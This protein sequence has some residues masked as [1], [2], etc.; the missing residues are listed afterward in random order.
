MPRLT[1]EFCGEFV[2]RGSA[3]GNE[4]YEQK[5]SGGRVER[6]WHSRCVPNYAQPDS[7]FNAAVQ[8]AKQAIEDARR[9]GQDEYASFVAVVRLALDAQR[10]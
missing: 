5:W 10:V 2:K 9:L 4:P 1:C 6:A 3:R 8:K 7:P